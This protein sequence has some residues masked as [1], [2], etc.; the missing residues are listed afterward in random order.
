MA[1]GTTSTVTSTASQR[2]HATVTLASQ[3]HS[4]LAI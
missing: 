1:S 4:R 3:R 2:R